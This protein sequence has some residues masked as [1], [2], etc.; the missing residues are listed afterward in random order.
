[1]TE[2]IGPKLSAAVAAAT[3]AQPSSTASTPPTSSPGDDWVSAVPSEPLPPRAEPA[4]PSE[5]DNPI[6]SRDTNE[7]RGELEEL[8]EWLDSD[9][10]AT[11]EHILD[12]MVVLV[13][14]YE[15][16][17]PGT[18]PTVVSL[19]SVSQA[20]VEVVTN[21]G[22]KQLTHEDVQMLIAFLSKFFPRVPKTLIIQAL[23]AANE[24]ITA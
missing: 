5:P 11:P 7:W 18:L 21:N 13:A 19:E 23:K 14:A 12:L 2:G 24:R 4:A 6:P 16:M 17:L 22:T 3:G 15:K 10:G 20:L 8:G 9:P 1:M